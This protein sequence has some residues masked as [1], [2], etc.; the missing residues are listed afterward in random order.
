MNVTVTLS[1]DFV[2][3]TPQFWY[4]GHDFDLEGDADL[5]HTYSSAGE[6]LSNPGD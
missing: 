5:N 6:I 4:E 1:S 3:D 2:W